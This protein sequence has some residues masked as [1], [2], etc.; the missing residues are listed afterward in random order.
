M[1]CTAHD[2]A[3]D[4]KAP[5]LDSIDR[6]QK[7]QEIRDR[8]D[9]NTDITGHIL[10]APEESPAEEIPFPY[11]PRELSAYT[12]PPLE[13]V[14]DT[15]EE[16]DP[17]GEDAPS[18]KPPLYERIGEKLKGWTFP[19]A[20]ALETL[21]RQGKLPSFM[22]HI[23]YNT[24]GAKVRN[25]IDKVVTAIKVFTG[26]ITPQQAAQENK[27]NETAL[28]GQQIVREQKQPVKEFVKQIFG[29][30]G[31][32]IKH[33][34]LQAVT[35]LVPAPVR[36]VIKTGFQKIGRAVAGGFKTAAAKVG[37]FARSVGSKIASVLG[38]GKK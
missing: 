18:K 37:N 27:N 19:I 20:G 3:E 12:E 13:Y 29:K 10:P 35:A 15:P 30:A 32:A 28:L 8:L 2:I 23:D 7:P 24:L 21:K 16:K 33:V 25:G 6:M 1:L 11:D 34:A 26:K 9:F 22:R 14:E 36:Q 4:F 38:F 31:T 17:S 5:K